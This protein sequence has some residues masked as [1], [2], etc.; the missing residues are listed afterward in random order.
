M[1]RPGE[2]DGWMQVELWERDN[3]KKGEKLNHWSRNTG[4]T[5]GMMESRTTDQLV[6]GAERAGNHWSAGEGDW[7]GGEPLISGGRVLRGR[8]TTDQWGKGA[9]RAGN[10]WS[11]E[12]GCWEGGEPLIR[13]GRVVVTADFDTLLLLELYIYGLCLRFRQRYVWVGGKLGQ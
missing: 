13:G 9:E 1:N 10:H 6:K 4:R 2:S 12:E 8:G 5:E 11:A 3:K 7:E